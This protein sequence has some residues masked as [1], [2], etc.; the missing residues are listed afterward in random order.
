MPYI[1]IPK[2]A[3]IIHQDGIDPMVV[4]FPTEE[5]ARQYAKTYEAG[6]KGLW[7]DDPN[8]NFYPQVVP[9]TKGHRAM[10]RLAEA[11]AEEE[12]QAGEDDE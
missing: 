5:T 10:E 8:W 7:D 4:T 2:W 9:I 1:A 11:V 6:T 12:A 3:V